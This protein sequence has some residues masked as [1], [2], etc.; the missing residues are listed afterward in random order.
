MRKFLRRQLTY[1]LI[2][3][4][5]AFIVYLFVRFD[6]DSILLGVFVSFIAGVA[7]CGA[8]LFLERRFPDSGKDGNDAPV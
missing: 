8:V 7:V 2:G 5:V 3:F 1:F 4:I 6:A